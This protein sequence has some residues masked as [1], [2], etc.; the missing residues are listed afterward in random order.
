MHFTRSLSAVV[1]GIAV[2]I[3]ISAD[4]RF[5]SLSFAFR[6]PPNLLSLLS[7]KQV[8]LVTSHPHHPTSAS[9]DL[10]STPTFVRHRHPF[11]LASSTTTAFRLS[12]FSSCRSSPISLLCHFFSLV[13]PASFSQPPLSLLRTLAYTRKTIPPVSAS[14]LDSAVPGFV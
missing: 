11:L 4:C 7:S 12:F 3:A 13:D 5:D 1:T 10:A 14:L 2:A 9:L 6:H 8:S